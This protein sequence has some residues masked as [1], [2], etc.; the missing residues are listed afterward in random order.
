MLW[1]LLLAILGNLA[2]VITVLRWDE[3]LLKFKK[4]RYCLF[5]ILGILCTGGTIAIYFDARESRGESNRLSQKLEGLNSGQIKAAQDAEIRDQSQKNEIQKLQSMLEPFL[6]AARSRTPHA[7]DATA[8]RSLAERIGNLEIRARDRELSAETK[9][10]IV[11]IL[12]EV[13]G[14]KVELQVMAG[15]AESRRY[16]EQLHQ[17]FI[18]ARWSVH[19]PILVFDKVF[20][21]GLHIVVQQDSASAQ[22]SALETALQATGQSVKGALNKSLNPD[23]LRVVVGP[24]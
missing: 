4:G 2:L 8:L 15:D 24:K 23:D 3:K 19:G 22:L 1:K 14:A 20:P 21:Q 7:D 9:A 18:E 11:R 10:K 6:V 13:Q 17:C 12:S 16:T 5:I